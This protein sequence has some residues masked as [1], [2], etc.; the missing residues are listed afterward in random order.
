MKAAKSPKPFWGNAW[1][2][3]IESFNDYENRLPRGRTYARNGSVCHLAIKQG[4]I[5]GMVSGSEIYNVKIT[6]AKLS[7]TKWQAIKNQC[8]GQIASLM[9]LLSGK[10]S[11]GVMDI[12]CDEND[13][14][15]PKA[16]EIKLTCDCPDWADMCKHIAAVLYGVGARLDHAPSQLFLLR[17]VDHEELVDVTA[18]IQEISSDTGSSRRRVADDNLADVFGIDLADEV[19]KAAK[20]PASKKRKTVKKPKQK[21]LNTFPKRFSGASIRKKRIAL[22]LTQAAFAKK[23]AVSASTVSKWE[24]RGRLSIN[25]S[26]TQ[27]NKLKR[28]WGGS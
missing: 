20:T 3:H 1:N 18:T 2:T 27:L 10:L 13:G 21:N 17:G 6:M 26:V 15:F 19:Q 28:L 14:L 5:E 23:L 11:D 8:K 16:D 9:D 25:F 24:C 7:A 22:G 12:V 4:L